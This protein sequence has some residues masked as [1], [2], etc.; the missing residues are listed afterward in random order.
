MADFQ[1]T[2]RYV[3]LR[4]LGS[5]SFGEVYEVFDR[6]RQIKIALKLPHEATA[7]GLY[8]FKREF[9]SLIDVTHPNLVALYELVGDQDRWFFTMELV[10]GIHFRDYLREDPSRSED[11][12][13][14]GSSG[15]RRVTPHFASGRSS[16]ADSHGSPPAR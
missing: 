7:G 12:R 1:G 6:E 13:S 15:G 11:K 16:N 10:N 8:Y 9:R 4:Y 5:G 3:V 14:T 2:D